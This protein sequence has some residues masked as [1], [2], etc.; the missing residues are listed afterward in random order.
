[1][2]QSFPVSSR[3]RVTIPPE[4]RSRLGLKPGDRVEF[5]VEADHAIIRPA[6]SAQ[7]PFEEYAGALGTFPGGEDEMREWLDELRSDEPSR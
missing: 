7:N 1:M 5:V 3:G 2:P 4:I 6:R